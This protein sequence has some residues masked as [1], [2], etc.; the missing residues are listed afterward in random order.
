MCLSYA[1]FRARS[2][3]RY[4]T[5]APQRRQDLPLHAARAV[6]VYDGHMVDQATVMM[7][8]QISYGV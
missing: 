6:R 5:V 1:F 3:Y 4:T 8:S 2:R 7:S